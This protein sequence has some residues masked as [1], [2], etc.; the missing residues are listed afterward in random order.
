MYIFLL[1]SEEDE[2]NFKYVCVCVYIHSQKVHVKG[3]L[4][5]NMCTQLYEVSLT[6]QI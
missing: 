2:T 1:K 4:L 3:Y 6:H 5:M